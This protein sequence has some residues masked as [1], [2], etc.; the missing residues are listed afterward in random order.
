L[1]CHWFICLLGCR[2]VGQTGSKER[3]RP[4]TNDHRILARQAM[5]QQWQQVWRTGVTG[6]F[7]HSIR[8]VVSVKPW[9][10]GQVEER[11]FVT[12]ISRVMSGHCLIRAHLERFRIVGDPICVCM[13]NYETVDHTIWECSR[14]E[15]ERCRLLLGLAAVNIKGGTPIRDLCALQKWAALRLCHRFLR[16]CGLKI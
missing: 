12:T 14:F 11:I 15:V 16:K 10:D 3:H 13:M 9:F 7:A 2:W 8:P 6:R 1:S 4:R 5:L